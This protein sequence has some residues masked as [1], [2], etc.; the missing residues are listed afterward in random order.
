MIDYRRHAYFEKL[1]RD[2]E[3]HGRRFGK[4]GCFR[5]KVRLRSLKPEG[6]LAQGMFWT[7]A[8]GWRD[9]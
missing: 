1:F 2:L 8:N 9:W 6:Y 7:E 4:R 5:I 3:K